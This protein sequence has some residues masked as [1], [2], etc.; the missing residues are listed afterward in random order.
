MDP[1]NGTNWTGSGCIGNHWL[2]AGETM[3]SNCYITRSS[4]TW[5][6]QQ[7]GP[8]TDANNNGLFLKG[9]HTTRGTN[10]PSGMPRC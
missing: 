1:A 9:I 3:Q 6:R 8:N 5:Y 4:G 7:S 10:P 2:Y